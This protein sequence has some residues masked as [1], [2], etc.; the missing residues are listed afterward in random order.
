MYLPSQLIISPSFSLRTMQW[1]VTAVMSTDIV[2]KDLKNLRND[3]WEQAFS[4]NNT[5]STSS[6]P[7]EDLNRKATIVVEHIIQA[8]DI[9]HTMQ[10]W[11]VYLKWNEKLFQE[12]YK[13]FKEGRSDNDPT[14]FWYEG[15]IGFFDLYIIR[16]AK[17]LKECGVF[18]VSSDEYLDYALANR[19]EW[20]ARG[21]DV[22][23]RY[24][25][26]YAQNPESAP[27]ALPV[28]SRSAQSEWAEVTN[29]VEC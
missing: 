6:S 25:A 23:D 2:D 13:A 15:E 22:V 16:V 18:G 12:M 3:R 11:H 29:E 10:H 14:K 24:V 26:T 9:S 19:R 8:S 5:A 28:S 4:E 7:M 21:R 17:K 27:R 20:A 1:V